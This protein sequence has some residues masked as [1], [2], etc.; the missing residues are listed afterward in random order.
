MVVVVVPRRQEPA[1]VFVDVPRSEALQLATSAARHLE[2]KLASTE[3][4]LHAEELARRERWNQHWWVRALPILK[5]DTTP[6]S[7]DV[8]DVGGGDTLS[9]LDAVF[10]LTWLKSHAESARSIAARAA[11]SATPY[12]P[13]EERLMNIIRNWSSR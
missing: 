11:R 12:L 13:V 1:P 5:S 2:R 9:G 6:E 7:I 8:W 4:N 10:K 3:A